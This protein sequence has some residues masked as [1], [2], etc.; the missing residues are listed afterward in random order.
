MTS[1]FLVSPSTPTG[2]NRRIELAGMDLMI[3]ARIDNVFVYP[4]EIKIDQLKE[5]LSRTLSLW[6]FVAGRI[7]L[8][9]DQHYIIEMCDNPISVTLVV[10]NDLK[11][12]P[13]DSNVIVEL[14]NKLFPTFIDEVQVTKLFNNP[15]DE[16]LVR[17]K[18]THIVQSDEWVLGISW[19]HPLGDAAACVHFSNTLSRFYQQMEPTQPLPLFER[20]LWREDEAHQSV[21]PVPQQFRDAQPTEVALETSSA[22]QLNY[23][24]LN[25]HFSSKQLATLRTLAGGNSVTTQDALT[26]YIILTLNTYCYTNNDQR[27]ILHTVTIVNF[28]GVS[29]FI[30][31]QGEVSNALFM[32][33]SDDFD[34]PY[35]L[36]TIAKT[37]RR[38]IIQS[39]DS[40][41]L[42]PGIATVDGL[43]RKNVRNNK[44]PNPRLVPH[45]FAVNSNF[46][47]DW[48]DLVDFGYTDKCRFYTAWS[49]ALYLRVFRLNPEKGEKKWLP[50]DRDG[51]EASFRVEKDLKEKF[52]NAWKRDIN[53]N[54]QN[55]KK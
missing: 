47:Y 53:E 9:N 3:L 2:N 42:E 35:S 48:A 7:V 5:A 4:S 54:F 10:N 8:E 20:R 29:D 37:I 55:V 1:S 22:H 30:A 18:L 49:G 34:D 46:R 27:R 36:S 33:L 15:S 45:E 19:Y 24:P 51:A 26:A 14:D 44:S 13:L 21:L 31:P 17:L 50:R 11:E 23:E 32:M 6:P 40:K 28:R 16:P 52:I 25:L 38:S 12:W 39:R 43:M 41:V